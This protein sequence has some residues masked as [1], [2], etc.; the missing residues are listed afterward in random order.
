MSKSMIIWQ[1]KTVGELEIVW[2][3]SESGKTLK[4]E[5]L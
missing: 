2:E 1:K 4:P 3:G 5:T